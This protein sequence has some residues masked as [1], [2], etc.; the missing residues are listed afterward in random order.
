MVRAG[1]G[2]PKAAQRLGE[3]LSDAKIEA[4][5]R[6]KDGRLKLD[7]PAISFMIQ[8]L[9]ESMKEMPDLLEG[10]LDLLILKALHLRLMHG[11]GISALIHRMSKEVLQVEQGSFYP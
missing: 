9:H 7:L 8:G 3:G 1:H 2:Q 5:F 10:T 6:S 11:L 4:F